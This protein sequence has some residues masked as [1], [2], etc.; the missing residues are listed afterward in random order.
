M[1][2]CAVV[3]CGCSPFSGVLELSP[4]GYGGQY[5]F[6]NMARWR[7]D[8]VYGA[9]AVRLQV[10]TQSLWRAVHDMVH[11]IVHVRANA[12][13]AEPPTMTRRARR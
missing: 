10:D 8:L 5:H 9:L 7:G 3:C 11:R 1:L 13:I 6:H 2:C 4:P 12:T